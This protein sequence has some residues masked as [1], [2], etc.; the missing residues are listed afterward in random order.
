ME[1]CFSSNQPSCGLRID[2]LIKTIVVPCHSC[3]VGSRFNFKY[4]K[5]VLAGFFQTLLNGGLN[6]FFDFSKNHLKFDH[7]L[8]SSETTHRNEPVL[9]GIVR[10]RRFQ[11]VQAHFCEWSVSRAICVQTSPDFSANFRE[12]PNFRGGARG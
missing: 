9:F 1:N 8:H 11:K 12:T 3:R 6:H 4:V 2:F 10:A 5:S 7:K